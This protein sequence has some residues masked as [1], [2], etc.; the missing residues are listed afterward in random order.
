MMP[1]IW[2][3]DEIEQWGRQEQRREAW[4]WCW[5]LT[6]RGAWWTCIIGA[7]YIAMSA[8]VP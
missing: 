7:L 2:G 1:R 4:A 8:V 6:A 3:D 5:S